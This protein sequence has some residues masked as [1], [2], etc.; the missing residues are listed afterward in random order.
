MGGG[1]QGNNAWT[2]HKSTE[3]EA[4]GG[5]SQTPNRATME[6]LKTLQTTSFLDKEPVPDIYWSEVEPALCCADSK[7]NPRLRLCY[8]VI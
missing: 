7:N 8:S 4:A 3:R 5:D 6:L 1:Q 2:D